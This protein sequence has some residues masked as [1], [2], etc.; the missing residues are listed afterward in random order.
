MT[1]RPYRTPPNRLAPNR[2][3][4][5]M[6]RRSDT[7]LFVMLAEP[8]E[9]W[10][11]EALDAA[12]AEIE[13]RQLQEPQQASLEKEASGTVKRARAGLDRHLKIAGFVLGMTGLGMIVFLFWWGFYKRSGEMRKSRELAGWTAAGIAF[14]IVITFVYGRIVAR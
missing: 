10:E 9:D 3:D 8:A 4:D 13:R 1:V 11:P 12:R 5:A 14:A 6:R 2:F 7:E